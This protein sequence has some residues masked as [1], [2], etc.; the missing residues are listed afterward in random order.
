MAFLKAVYLSVVGLASGHVI[1]SDVAGRAAPASHRDWCGTG[2]APKGLRRESGRGGH[3]PGNT[4]QSSLVVDTY[5]HVVASG[6]TVADGYLRDETIS[7]QFA[8]LGATY[9]P[10]GISF[11][12]AG[13]DHI[14]NPLWATSVDPADHLVMKKALRKGSYKTLN[15]YYRLVVGVSATGDD[16]LGR[17][18]FP[19]DAVTPGSDEF[20]DDGCMIL[21]STVPG[22]TMEDANLGKTTTHE[23]GHR[24][25]LFHTFHGGCLAGDEVSD[26]PAEDEPSFACAARDT[27]PDQPGLDPINNN[28]DYSP[29]SC[30]S[31]FT[32]GQR[33]RI[34]EVWQLT[35]N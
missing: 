16:L 28:M 4:N 2:H 35:R 1:R 33:V 18:P 12:L 21:S 10:T 9:A 34:F 32:P 24:F 20:Y 29:D 7:Q 8:A 23:V 6:T 19:E 31:Q 25:G 13:V 3:F 15:L 30:V 11:N 27:C 5:T 26:T 17:C 14:I 22:G